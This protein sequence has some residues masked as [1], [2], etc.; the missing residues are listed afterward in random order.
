MWMVQTHSK[1]TKKEPTSTTTANSHSQ[2]DFQKSQVSNPLK[3]TI[4]ALPAFDWHQSLHKDNNHPRAKGKEMVPTSVDV[5]VEMRV[6]SVDLGTTIMQIATNQGQ[7]CKG[8]QVATRNTSNIQT[9][10]TV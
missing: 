3:P 5:E 4:I 10:T 7:H 2:L 1:A 9:T 8:K 6:A